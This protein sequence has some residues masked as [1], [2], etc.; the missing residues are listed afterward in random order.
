L[1]SNSSLPQRRP[2][3]RLFPSPPE[4][5]RRRRRHAFFPSP[6]VVTPQFTALHNYGDAA[7]LPLFLLPPGVR[8]P[9]YLS[10]GDVEVRQIYHLLV[11]AVGIHVNRAPP[12]SPPA[13]APPDQVPSSLC[14]RIK[15]PS[16]PVLRRRP[17]L[18]LPTPQ[19]QLLLP[20]AAGSL[21]YLGPP[22]RLQPLR[23][24]H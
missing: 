19:L 24:S 5:P 8:V 11:C 23:L 18:L 6:T 20:L 4:W 21:R 7:R 12:P 3:S 13:P 10:T 1:L 15:L 2:Y 16:P 9:G 22:S 14:R 17:W